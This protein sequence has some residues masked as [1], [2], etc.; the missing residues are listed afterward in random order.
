MLKAATKMHLKFKPTFF[1]SPRAQSS[2]LPVCPVLKYFCSIYLF[3][4]SLLLSRYPFSI[5]DYYGNNTQVIN[6]QI[7]IRFHH[8]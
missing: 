2:L 8:R 7:Q 1:A 5:H 3:F 6:D 4:L